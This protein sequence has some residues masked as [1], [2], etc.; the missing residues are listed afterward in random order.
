M[1][2]LLRMGPLMG[3]M[4][5]PDFRRTIEIVVPEKLIVS[6]KEG[7]VA[8]QDDPLKKLTF[9]FMSQISADTAYFEFTEYT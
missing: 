7:N 9:E 1:K 4:D 5:I 2:A 6:S 8:I 3:V